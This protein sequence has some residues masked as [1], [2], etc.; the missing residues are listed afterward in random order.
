VLTVEVSRITPA[1]MDRKPPIIS[2]TATTSSVQPH[3]RL[4]LTCKS[5]L[6]IVRNPLRALHCRLRSAPPV[7]GPCHHEVKQAVTGSRPSVHLSVV[8][9]N[10]GHTARWYVRVETPD[11]RGVFSA[12]STN[13]SD[14]TSPLQS[15]EHRAGG[16]LA[17]QS[18][19]CR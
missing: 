15:S 16:D 5:D 19:I 7:D 1:Q 4:P 12:I 3:A 2:E 6:T 13:I 9:R 14:R 8:E 17:V 11:Q 10:R 18:G